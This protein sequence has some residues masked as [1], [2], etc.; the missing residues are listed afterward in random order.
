MLSMSYMRS[1]KRLEQES[2]R[3]GLKRHEEFVRSRLA[4]SKGPSN[5]MGKFH[6]QIT[7]TYSAQIRF[8][9]CRRKVRERYLDV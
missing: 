1:I 9:M 4:V 2:S 3:V 7:I 5:G 8:K 6:T